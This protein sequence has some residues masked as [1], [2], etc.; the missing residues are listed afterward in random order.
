MQGEELLAPS[1]A[2]VINSGCSHVVPSRKLRIALYSHDTMGIGHMRRNALI[3]S[4]IAGSPRSAAILLVCGAREAWCS[5]IRGGAPA[6][7]PP[8]RQISRPST[9]SVS[10][11]MC[12]SMSGVAG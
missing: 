4:A 2:A 3:A 5:K 12:L 10:F 11:S 7:S 1:S 8:K 6:V 9:S